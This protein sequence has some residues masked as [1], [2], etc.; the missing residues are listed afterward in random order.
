MPLADLG[1]VKPYGSVVRVEGCE[2]IYVV[3]RQP[4]FVT[5]PLKG[6]IHTVCDA[7]LEGQCR[8]APRNEHSSRRKQRE[9]LS[10][11]VVHEF[12][13]SNFGAAAQSSQLAV[14]TKILLADSLSVNPRNADVQK[15]VGPS[16]MSWPLSESTGSVAD[17][18]LL[19]I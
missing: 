6:V 7:G 2:S 8:D 11:F 18:G 12:S 9:S 3:D 14:D 10:G 1:S 19:E 5:H 4:Q 15:I 17:V 16:S 13:S